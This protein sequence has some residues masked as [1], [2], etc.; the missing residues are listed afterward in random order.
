MLRS[1]G[2]NSAALA[3]PA[4]PSVV[5]SAPQSLTATTADDR[6]LDVTWSTPSSDG[7]SAITQYDLRWRQLGGSWTTET[8]VTSP[9]E[10]TDL[11]IGGALTDVEV[12]AVNG[13][14]AGASDTAS[15][16]THARAYGLTAEWNIPISTAVARGA[17]PHESYFV[18]R[19]RA[20]NC[21]IDPDD[22]YTYALYDVSDATETATLVKTY[23][24]A[25]STIPWNPS[26]G[27]PSG[28]DAQ[29]VLIDPS[30]GREW[31]IWQ[32]SY[33]AGSPGTLTVT[34]C[35]II[36]A[37][38][39]GTGGNGDYRTKANSFEEA[40]G[41]GIQY[42][43]MLVTAE[44]IAQG[45]IYH[46]LSLSMLHPGYDYF[47]APGTKGERA[48]GNN[49]NVGI[50]QGTRLYL[51]KTE[52]EIDTYLG[53]LPVQ[54]TTARKAAIKTVL[55]ALKDYGWI[56]TDTAGA[57]HMQVQSFESVDWADYDFDNVVGSDGKTYP[58]DILDNLIT[59]DADV[60]CVLPPDSVLYYS[61][62][63][64]LSPT[65]VVDPVVTGT[66]TLSIVTPGLCIGEATVTMT[67]NWQKDT[68]G[69][70]AD[71]TDA[72]GD[73]FDAASEG[74]AD[75][76]IRYTGTNSNGSTN[77]YSNEIT[78]APAWTQTD[79]FS[80]VTNGGWWEFTDWS[81]LKQTTGGTTDVTS[82]N[83]PV[84]YAADQSGLGNH[85]IRNV[86]TYG[87][88]ADS[89][90]GAVDRG[91]QTNAGLQATFDLGDT[92]GSD[93]TVC[94]ALTP[95]T[96]N[97][98]TAVGTRDGSTLGWFIR[99]EISGSDTAI[100]GQFL[101]AGGKA[102]TYTVT[103]STAPLQITFIKDGFNLDLR[104]NGVS[105][106]TDTA[107]GITNSSGAFTVGNRSASVAFGHSAAIYDVVAVD[108]VLTGADLTGTEARQSALL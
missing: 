30:D 41:V 44:E 52:G 9:Y 64:S 38:E 82:D 16:T 57:N 3:P 32:A 62:T 31:N 5:P 33:S 83:D 49:D 106:D 80:G 102:L 100:T 104:V 66:T 54:V 85:L 70:F 36:T 105:R 7:G 69:G 18:S 87:L 72:T 78:Y 107:T 108:K 59:S 14:G 67:K 10:L 11:P 6:T 92:D 27:I 2:G 28:S 58:R 43:A 84:Q 68:G 13:N 48:S 39:D 15:D 26:W 51:K 71:I 23:G 29:L 50:P 88:Y 97:T 20:A 21:N 101:G 89:A 56:V 86:H 35:N 81:T 90:S 96:A 42:F 99:V 63:A 12:W 34:R 79:A 4:V 77:A 98:T 65:K 55:M 61:E 1:H 19:F 24:N 53:T 93:M 74:A 95:C 75:Y 8:D 76:R 45:A 47:A 94:V 40:R 91:A 103:G 60:G 73:T 25:G 46:A 17:H 37:N 22:D